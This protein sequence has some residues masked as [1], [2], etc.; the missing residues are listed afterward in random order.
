LAFH[1][2]Q[3]GVPKPVRADA[4]GRHPRRVSA[5]GFPQVVVTTFGDRPAVG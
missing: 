2:G 4:L 1:P 5:N 3:R